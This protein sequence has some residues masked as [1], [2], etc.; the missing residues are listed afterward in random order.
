MSKSQRK[1][2]II[3]IIIIFLFIF[4]AIKWCTYSKEKNAINYA[5]IPNP[6]TKEISRQELMAF[7]P[8]WSDYMQQ[9]ISELEKH[10]VSLASGAPEENLSAEAKEW[11]LRR[12]WYPKRFFYV[13]Q[14]LRA[15]LKTI[16]YQEQSKDLIESL[17]KQ[18]QTLETIQAQ[19]ITPDPQL[20]SQM[21]G[22]Q[23]MIEEQQR[24]QNV[25]Q[26]TPEEIK[27]IE[28]IQAVIRE[29]LHKYQQ[30]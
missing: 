23:N 30:L 1:Q 25:E 28:P 7:L 12:L 14:R 3:K 11:L 19:N 27:M 16:E 4:G 18:Y 15:I 26:I 24:K 22:I 9:N 10:P 29:T 6:T 21:S 20:T 13:E 2:S 17:T 8:V 5:A